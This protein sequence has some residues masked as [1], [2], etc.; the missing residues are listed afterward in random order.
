MKDIFMSRVAAFVAA[1]C[2]TTL[3]L[4]GVSLAASIDGVDP[5]SLNSHNTAYLKNNVNPNFKVDTTLGKFR[6]K[7]EGPGG[8]YL[9]PQWSGGFN[10][11]KTVNLGGARPATGNYTAYLQY[12]N[13]ITG[14]WGSGYIGSPKQINNLY[15][16]TTVPVIDTAR[17]SPRNVVYP[18]PYPEFV[19]GATDANIGM[20]ECRV[21]LK[22]ASSNITLKSWIVTDG[23][24]RYQMSPVNS[25]PALEDGKIYQWILTAYDWEGNSSSETCN[26]SVSLSDVDPPDAQFLSYP[27]TISDT[28]TVYPIKIRGEDKAV[29]FS[30]GV[31]GISEYAMSEVNA[32]PATLTWN[33]ASGYGNPAVLDNLSYTFSGTATGTRNIYLWFRDNAS[34]ARNVTSRPAMATIN[35]TVSADT[36][37]PSP[38]P[39]SVRGALYHPGYSRSN[40]VILG[41]SASDNVG[42]THYVAREGRGLSQPQTGDSGWRTYPGAVD[43]PFMFGAGDGLKYVSVWY[44]DGAGNI[45]AV[46]EKPITIDGNPPK[47]GRVLYKVTTVASGLSQPYGVS[48]DS[49]GNVFVANQSSSNP[50]AGAIVKVDSGG[51]GTLAASPAE[52]RGV[53]YHR[54]TSGVYYCEMYGGGV[55]YYSGG[56]VNSVPYSPPLPRPA[57]IVRVSDGTV[58]VSDESAGGVYKMA[59]TGGTPINIGVSGLTGVR[60]MA[61]D[62]SNY[63]Y[64]ANYGAGTV[65][66]IIDFGS[67]PLF[68]NFASGIAGPAGVAVD[69]AGRVFVSD[70]ASSKVLC[71]SPSGRLLDSI[72][73]GVSASADGT[74]ELSSFAGPAGIAAEASG[75]LYVADNAAGLLRK[76]TPSSEDGIVINSGAWLTTRKK[77]KIALFATDDLAVMQ[78]RLVQSP[79]LP[80]IP[81]DGDSYWKDLPSPF[82]STLEVEYDLAPPEDED[83]LKT[84]HVWFRDEAG[85]VSQPAS[86]S[87]NLSTV[88]PPSIISGNISVKGGVSFL[89]TREVNLVLNAQGDP[90]YNIKVSAYYLSESPGQPLPGVGNWKTFDPV[91]NFTSEVKYMLSSMSEG[92][93]EIYV[94]YADP[95][96]DMS[97]RASCRLIVDVTPP[98]SAIVRINGAGAWCN[99]NSVSLSLGARDSVGITGYCLSESP[100][101]AFDRAPWREVAPTTDLSL[102]DVTFGMNTN[103]CEKKIYAYFRDGTGNV[104]SPAVAETRLDT[105]APVNG[106]L[107]VLVQ[108]FAGTGADLK[109]ERPRPRLEATFNNPYDVVMDSDGNMYV[110]IYGSNLIKKIDRSGMVTVFAGGGEDED[111]RDQ[112]Q[113]IPR[114][115]TIAIDKFN[116]I[117]AAGIE[118]QRVPF[119]SRMVKTDGKNLEYF[120]GIEQGPGDVDGS[121]FT[122]RV[123]SITGITVAPSGD[124]YFSDSYVGGS[125]SFFPIHKIKKITRDNMVATVAGSRDSGYRDGPG[126]TARFNNPTGMDS[127]LAG[128][129][130]VADME[131]NRI[132]KL[133]ADGNVSTVAGT[134]KLFPNLTQMVQQGDSALYSQ[135]YTPLS[136][137]SEVNLVKPFDVAVDAWGNVFEIEFESMVLRMIL[138]NGFVILL[139][140]GG[141]LG[142]DGVSADGYGMMASFHTPSGVCVGRDGAIYVTESLGHRIKKVTYRET[143]GLEVSGG[144]YFTT[145]A[146]SKLYLTSFDNY[147]GV[148]AYYLSE[149]PDFPS[150]SAASPDFAPDRWVEARRDPTAKDTPLFTA[151]VEVPV[152]INEPTTYHLWFRDA[153][154]NVSGSASKTIN[155]RRMKTVR[156]LDSTT[157]TVPSGITAPRFVASGRR[158]DIYA[159]D[160]ND[161]PCFSV[162]D[163]RNGNRI[164]P[165]TS[166]QNA[167]NLPGTDL[168]ALFYLPGGFLGIADSGRDR[169]SY[170][171]GGMGF[172]GAISRRFDLSANYSGVGGEADARNRVID[173]FGAAGGAGLYEVS[174]PFAQSA[175][176]LDKSFAA[177]SIEVYVTGDYEPHDLVTGPV[178]ISSNPTLYVRATGAGAERQV[179]APLSILMKARSSSDPSGITVQLS[180]NASGFYEGSFGIGRIVSAGSGCLGV[181]AGERITL[182]VDGPNGGVSASL[183]VEGEW[184]YLGRPGFS[185]GQS[186]SCLMATDGTGLYALY[187]D[188]S[189]NSSLVMM[190]YDEAG[191]FPLGPA[192]G[193]TPNIVATFNMT[194]SEGTPY[195]VYAEPYNGNRPTVTAYNGSS[196]STVGRPGFFAASVTS[197]CVKAF[198]GRLYL[199]FSFVDETAGPVFRI[200][201]LKFDQNNWV[202]AGPMIATESLAYYIGLDFLN[203]RPVVTYKNVGSA[204]GT[205]KYLE[206]GAWKDAGAPSYIMTGNRMDVMSLQTFNEVPY[207]FFVDIDGP[208]RDDSFG[209]IM[210]FRD[211]AW[212]FLGERGFTGMDIS[213]ISGFCGGD[214]AYVAFR[215]QDTKFYSMK[216][217]NGVWKKLGEIPNAQGLKISITEWNGKPCV[218]YADR[219]PGSDGKVSVRTY[220]E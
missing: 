11:Y 23:S 220:E 103:N 110:A 78:Y 83:G 140:G 66:K 70:S 187:S 38:G 176:R 107:E 205:A 17:L 142:S 191:W 37:V 10:G 32:D 122:A 60:L 117:Y 143:G 149:N 44:K 15:Y 148:A 152:R 177:S 188:I 129:I 168:R 88:S 158:N 63:I 194:V 35:V 62:S 41:I 99:S 218:I 98:D 104:S 27:S 216:W 75:I 162:S 26:F 36:A 58:Y 214:S 43:V 28:F 198:E 197:P 134:G 181:S 155:R 125:A 69:A 89:T 124:I 87:I 135:I 126:L 111:S 130:Y 157:T 18:S 203:G 12:R 114:L 200:A 84:F 101:T 86:A 4:G 82:T 31:T 7:L 179:D 30:S 119:D 170:F 91:Q 6:V 33:P 85:N 24:D 54:P 139:A 96:G 3:L 150:G 51:V 175:A 190:K 108:T 56:S 212:R 128:N 74:N 159:L 185:A 131:N 193:F 192:E 25:D 138:P 65:T 127:D 29:T 72:G 120:I 94:W 1:L 95:A 76:I 102:S 116:V 169:F 68:M 161:R 172:V 189:R 59:A 21:E 184:R 154:G 34:P 213:Y 8:T 115:A 132:R 209:S 206:S 118:N 45:S 166:S 105:M 195:V 174:P 61:L 49:G 199:V 144:K 121:I 16:D 81:E 14:N 202:A 183:Q 171:N 19:W 46:S 64:T 71:Y 163:D 77:L 211:G 207:L 217:K 55:K 113:F 201:F 90:L 133:S 57:G 80:A 182:L 147:S 208:R 153:A 2:A 13:P 204:L 146:S 79:S 20:K 9:S 180:H 186:Q 42:V 112:F 196:W 100:V 39:L 210:T 136:T 164:V 5:A 53:F 73:S 165:P 67:S 48:T 50:A 145:S 92:T 178:T 215:G 123:V 47:A 22:D 52:P 106:T 156:I 97:A 151:E 137:S 167:F 109:D 93:R 40:S 173:K 160:A 219:S 141:P